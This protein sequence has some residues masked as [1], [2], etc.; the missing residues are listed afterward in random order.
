LQGFQE[1]KNELI[2]TA[3]LKHR[4]LVQLLG[5]CMEENE[6][7]IVYEYMPN[8]S[9]DT[10]LFG[11]SIQPL[12]TSIQPVLLRNLSARSSPRPSLAQMMV[13]VVVGDGVGRRLTGAR[14]TRSSAVSPAACCTSTRSPG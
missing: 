13:V 11:T 1:L 2:L 12:D 7:L 6:K 8:R 14:D 4:N 10:H 9:L 5:I 3:K